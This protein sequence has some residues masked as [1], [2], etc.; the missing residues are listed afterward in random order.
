MSHVRPRTGAGFTL[1]ELLVVISIIAL[2]IA[3]LLPALG[4]A[5]EAANRIKCLSNTRQLY[6]AHAFYS[7]EFV[8]LPLREGINSWNFNN[9]TH[10]TVFQVLEQTNFLTEDGLKCPSAVAPNTNFYSQYFS[11]H[12]SIEMYGSGWSSRGGNDYDR[13]WI[14]MTRF[15][16]TDKTPIACDANY[17]DNNST[18]GLAVSNPP[19]TDNIFIPTGMNT[20]WADGHGSWTD[21]EGLS[22]HIATAGN[23]RNFWYPTGANRLIRDFNKTSPKSYY[24]GSGTAVLRGKLSPHP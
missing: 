19:T 23:Y 7:R 2:L 12:A 15:D 18:A 17:I 5:R 1:V 9:G 16:Y 20:A 4:Q 10:R 8:Y 11:P 21:R 24:F 13:Y 14:D 6:I 3:M 22:N